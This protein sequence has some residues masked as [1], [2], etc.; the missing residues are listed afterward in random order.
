MK[1]SRKQTLALIALAFIIGCARVPGRQASESKA[2]IKRSGWDVSLLVALKQKR[3][4]RLKSEAS[5]AINITELLVP[6]EG[7]LLEDTISRIEGDAQQNGIR[8]SPMRVDH[9]VKYEVNGRVFCYFVSG[10]GVAI[11]RI[12]R[13]E[14]RVGTLGCISAFAF[15]DEDGDGKFESLL[16][17]NIQVSFEPHIPDWASKI[18]G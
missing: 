5:P 6:A 7:V 8:N 2:L 12:S 4:L 1:R 18:R 15:Y 11:A 13:E 3:N 17:W 9:A 14:T 10:P 16:S